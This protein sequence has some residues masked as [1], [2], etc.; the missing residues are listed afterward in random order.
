MFWSQVQD[1]YSVDSFWGLRLVAA[2]L[3]YCLWS[4]RAFLKWVKEEMLQKSMKG[5]LIKA[6]KDG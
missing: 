3:D 5:S 6:C 4:I 2:K 1:S